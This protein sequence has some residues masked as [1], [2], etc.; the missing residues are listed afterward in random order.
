MRLPSYIPYDRLTIRCPPID[1]SGDLSSITQ[2]MMVTALSPKQHREAVF[3][4][5]EYFHREI[6]TD[7]I[8]FSPTEKREY[9][10]YLW[11]VPTSHRGKDRHMAFG[12]CCFRRR[13]SKSGAGYI[14]MQ[15]AW[16]HPMMRGIGAMRS[17]WSMFRRDNG[18]FHVEP[19]L[20]RAMKRFME[21]QAESRVLESERIR[22]GRC[23]ECGNA[24][25]D[26]GGYIRCGSCSFSISNGTIGD[27]YA[28]DRDQEFHRVWGVV[29]NPFIP[30]PKYIHGHWPIKATP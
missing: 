20:S 30:D 27:G 16:I 3:D 1:I 24:L 9:V 19:P 25:K 10:A 23:P 14:A 22:I 8:Q 29:T 13:S 7:F 5:A 2:P 26:K 15:W 17:A 4:I 11:L 18:D 28:I 6:G 21:K 12:A